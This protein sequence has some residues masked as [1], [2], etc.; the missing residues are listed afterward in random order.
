MS[1][2][3]QLIKK[4]AENKA[5]FGCIAGQR[6]DGKSTLAGTLPGKT[7]LVEAAII[8]AGSDSAARL[9][10]KLGN[11]LDTVQFHTLNDLVEILM[12]VKD[13]DYDHVYVDGLSAI[14]EMK[15]DEPE[16][17]K[18]MNKNTWD[19]YRKI[20]EAV[21][22]A[23]K[24]CKSI[25]VETG[26]NVF[27]TLA[28]NPK[29]DGNGVLLELTPACKGNVATSEISKLCKFFGTLR[30]REDEEGNTIRE[31]V[32]STDD[33]YLGRIDG[34]LEEENPGVIGADLSQLLKLLAT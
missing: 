4:S 18:I 15:Y 14:T 8:E 23:L 27:I 9:A 16:V 26:K 2:I 17:Q 13:T 25:P 6:M 22:A 20:A 10:K 33:V 5:I 12:E 1:K 19:G 28:M 31:L 3:S 30:I 29:R 34:L 11:H 21:R 7:L 24:L 32:T